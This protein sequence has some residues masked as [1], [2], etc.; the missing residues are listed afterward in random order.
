MKL[1]S[2]TKLGLSVGYIDC[3]RKLQVAS[4]KNK[5]DYVLVGA[6]ARDVVFAHYLGITSQRLTT[7]ID[8]GLSVD[9]WETFYK[10]KASLVGL[11]FEE[12]TKSQHRLSYSTLNTAHDIGD[13]LLD[14][15]QLDIVPHGGINTANN[16]I[17]WPPDGATVM[18]VLGFQ[19]AYE[20]ALT[21]NIEADLSIRVLSVPGLGLLKLIAWLDRPRDLRQKDALDL[22]FSLLNY[23]AL[24]NI[25]EQTFDQ[26]FAGQYGFEMH[27]AFAAKFGQDIRK[28]CSQQSTNYLTENIFSDSTE[29]VLEQ[30][31]FDM[32][33]GGSRDD[34]QLQTNFEMLAALRDGFLKGTS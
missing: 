13:Y 20:S 28:I 1:A 27:K 15:V 29:T 31:A 30:L 26:D 11:G 5:V 33:A 21:I 32:N 10:F 34:S 25:Q 3:F 22:K 6:H 18:S 4:Q 9:S 7:D 14:I 23:D 24:P 2:A 8:I 19:E 12:N 17:G 16:E